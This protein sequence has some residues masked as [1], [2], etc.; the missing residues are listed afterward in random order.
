M[1]Y[2]Q[3]G[4]D[5]GNKPG[6][7]KLHDKKKYNLEEEQVADNSGPR[8]K[9]VGPATQERKTEETELIIDLE[10]KIEFVQ[11]DITEGKVSEA[12]GKELI[13]GYRAKIAKLR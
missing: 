11:N 9:V 4:M 2:K 6:A 7:P 3:K 8:A 1:A 5:F 10:D 13:A 12:S